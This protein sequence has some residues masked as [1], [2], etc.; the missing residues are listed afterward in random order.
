MF[1][2]GKSHG[3]RSLGGHSPWGHP[4]SD[5]TCQLSH[6]SDEKDV[7]AE[8]FQHHVP[9]ALPSVPD[10]HL[11]GKFEE[12][13]GRRASRYPRLFLGGVCVCLSVVCLSVTPL[14]PLKNCSACRLC[15]PLEPSARFAA[16]DLLGVSHSLQRDQ[17]QQ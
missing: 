16:H 4:E 15:I 8:Q 6:S 14:L 9:S 12:E 3:H 2:P 7:H 11:I 17:Q 10:G 1:L 5:T 13:L